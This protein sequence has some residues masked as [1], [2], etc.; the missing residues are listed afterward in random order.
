MKHITICGDIRF[1]MLVALFIL[2]LGCGTDTP[3]CTDSFCLVPRDDVEGEV[4]EVD[5]NKVLALIAKTTEPTPVITPEPEPITP[6]TDNTVTLADIVSD[7]VENTSSSRFIGQDVEVEGVVK[8]NFVVSHNR[9]AITLD[10]NTDTVI[11][12]ITDFDTPETLRDYEPESTYTFNLHIRSVLES[13]TT[14]GLWLVYAH[15]VP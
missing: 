7:V 14:Q 11:F 8:F 1:M 5:E 6:E 12:Y 13:Q 9:G 4:I 2:T 10:T 15:E 3:V